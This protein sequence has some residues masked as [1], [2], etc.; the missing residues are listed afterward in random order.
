[1]VNA[2]N[3]AEM[4]ALA[5]R[6]LP[7]GLFEYIDRGTEDEVALAAVREAW[8][9]L[10]L[11]PAV[12]VDVSER[13][14]DTVLFGRRLGFPAVIAPTA[15]AGLVWH[16][17][18]AALARAAARADI[19]FCVST[20]SVTPIEHIA[21][22]GARLWFQLYVWRDRQLMLRLLERA[23]DAGAEALILTVDTAV[24]PNREY[25]VRN[26]FGM[27][28]QPSLRAAIDVLSRPRWLA[29]VLLRQLLA[30]GV[31]TYAHYP[32]EFRTR[33]TRPAIADAVRLDD[34]V[35]W[36]DVAELRRSWRGPF[37]LKGILRVDDARRALEAG[38]DGIVVSSHGG[39]NLDS[40][41]P[42]IEALPAIV[43][44]VGDRMTVLV[45]G[46]VR[47]GS[48]IAK[49]LALG[50]KAVLVGRATLYGTAFGGEAG[51][52][53]MLDLLRDE[54]GRTMGLIGRPTV[55]SIGP[56]S[57]VPHR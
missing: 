25:N 1:M 49:A 17:G 43:D 8:D 54:L 3:Y 19:P 15:L 9:R 21:R 34:R 11:A 38:I 56:D 45:D 57:L 53:R 47:R 33:V 51:A 29:G 39:R 5:R 44:A 50:A 24:G 36:R 12:L 35:S 37:L 26:G 30:D 32:P 48:H 22:S 31:P 46:G 27:P 52:G 18:E 13:R 6:R 4:R 41:P 16:D 7:R 42:A 2:L 23:R 40:A 28:I 10:K 55:A 20:Q 14:M